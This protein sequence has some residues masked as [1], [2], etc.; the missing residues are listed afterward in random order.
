MDYSDIDVQK[1]I[2]YLYSRR[3]FCIFCSRTPKCLIYFSNPTT[4][5]IQNFYA[6]CQ[7]HINIKLS[8]DDI[9]KIAITNDA[10]DDLK[11]NPRYKNAD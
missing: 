7:K 10:K 11:S 1:T 5:R 8:F 6:V 3:K 2:D 9:A 4:K